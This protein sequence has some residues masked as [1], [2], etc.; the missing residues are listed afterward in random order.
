MY[1]LTKQC[2]LG[3]R[4]SESCCFTLRTYTLEC[5]DVGMLHMSYPPIQPILA[6][7]SWNGISISI[8]LLLSNCS[9]FT[10]VQVVKVIS[11]HITSK[12]LGRTVCH[13]SSITAPHQLPWY[14]LNSC[15]VSILPPNN[16]SERKIIWSWFRLHH[17]CPKSLSPGTVFIF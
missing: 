12:D 7:E 14:Q 9:L 6:K 17:H 3:A 5:E 1:L 16:N 11:F 10:E 15:Q 2:Q 4:G 8:Q 13:L